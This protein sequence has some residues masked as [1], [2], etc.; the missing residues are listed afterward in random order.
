SRTSWLEYAAAPQPAMASASAMTAASGR[1]GVRPRDGMGSPFAESPA[2]HARLPSAARL[3]G[4]RLTRG[5]ASPP[6]HGFASIGKEPPLVSRAG[7]CKGGAIAGVRH[8]AIV[9]CRVTDDRR[10]TPRVPWR[11]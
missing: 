11:I 10:G 2:G 7:N 6:H 9:N 5:F 1:Y 4:A 8:E 3:S